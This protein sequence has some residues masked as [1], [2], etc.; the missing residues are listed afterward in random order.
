MKLTAQQLDSVLELFIKKFGEWPGC[1]ERESIWMRELR[2]FRAGYAAHSAT[3]ETLQAAQPVESKH[4]L[5]KDGDNNVPSTLLDRNGQIVL[6]MCRICGK[7]EGELSESCEQAGEPKGRDWLHKLFDKPSHKRNGPDIVAGH[8]A[9]DSLYDEREKLIAQTIALSKE[10]AL[11]DM[12]NE[13]QIKI[14]REGSANITNSGLLGHWHF[15]ALLDNMADQL[16]YLLI[17]NA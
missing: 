13:A 3:L 2:A 5:Y 1:G 10:R 6:S 16:N 14:L 11:G 7:A 4:Y 8:R 15:S 17:T 9:I 12:L